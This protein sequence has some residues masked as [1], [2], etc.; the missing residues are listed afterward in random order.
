MIKLKF[1]GLSLCFLVFLSPGVLG[2]DINIDYKDLNNNTTNMNKYLG[3][4]LIVD[5]FATWCEPCK[6]EIE[7]LKEIYKVGSNELNI[8]SLSVDENSDTLNKIKNFRNKFEATWEFGIDH[9]SIFENSFKVIF[10]P[11]LYIFDSDGKIIK[12]WEGVTS[13]DTISNELRDS[14]NL[15]LNSSNYNA[16]DGITNQLTQNNLFQVTISFLTISIVYILIVP[17]VKP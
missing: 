4:P 15:H 2:S 12:S 9:D 16:L 3:K 10:I 8:L 5:A 6:I 7:H 14:L 17:K 11:S 1:L 13:Y